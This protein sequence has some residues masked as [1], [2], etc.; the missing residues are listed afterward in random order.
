MPDIAGISTV[1]ASIKAASD[2]ART[3]RESGL[4]LEQAE[5]KLKLAELIDKLVDAKIHIASIQEIL[6]EKEHSM[7]EL[8]KALE[9]QGKIAYE[10]PSYWLNRGSRREGPFC[11]QCYDSS[12]K[13]IRLQ[14]HHNGAWSCKTCSSTYTDSRFNSYGD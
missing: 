3:I 5:Y 14:D 11:Q 13:M 1:L 8:E 10:P 7:K 12:R 9:I 6:L 2:I 4:T